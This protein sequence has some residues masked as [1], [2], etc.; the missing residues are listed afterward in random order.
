MLTCTSGIGLTLL[1]DGS[2][3]KSQIYGTL[4]LVGTGIGCTFQPTL[5]ALQAHTPTS[6]RAVTISMRNFFR[7]TGGA[8]GL[9]ISAAILQS[10]LKENLP[11]GYQYL[12]KTT[13]AL[14]DQGSIPTADWDAIVEAY[15]KASHTVFLFQV[16]LVG[17][18]VLGCLFIRDKGLQKQEDGN[19][20]SKEDVKKEEEQVMAHKDGTESQATTQ[21]DVDI[22]IETPNNGETLDRDVEKQLGNEVDKHAQTAAKTDETSPA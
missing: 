4:I 5:V 20:G 7:C 1:W 6:Q 9:A 21:I 11:A 18:C 10:V 14:P 22:D 15:V 12:T 17:A 2:T 16:P 3:P 8:V 13:Y 19:K